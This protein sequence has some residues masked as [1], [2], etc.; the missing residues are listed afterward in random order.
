MRDEGSRMPAAIY[1]RVSSERQDVDLSISA[2]LKAIREYAEKGGYQVVRE[3]VDEAESG[4]SIDRP[5]FKAM[6]AS[7]RQKP[8]PFEAILVWKL[9][10]FARNREDS[11]IYKSLLR[12]Q[13]VQVISINEPVEDTPSGRLL[14]GIIEVIDEFYSANL[15]QDVVR[16]MRENA[17]RGFF[18]GS[19][20]PY[21]YRRIKAQD[22]DAQRT[23][24]EP[25]PATAPLVE[26]MFRECLSGKGLLEIT[27]GLNAD[28]LTTRTGRPWSKT[29]IH[30]VLRNEAY[31][32]VLLWGREKKRNLGGGNGLPP[33][34]VEGAWQPIID[35]ETLEKVQA[36][37]A[38]RA[39]KMTHPRVVHS[40]Y[41]L[42][43][44]I[45]C[46]ACGTAMIGH[47]VKS[48]KFF[49]YMCGNAR[50]RGREVCQ[51]PILPKDRIERFVI[52][53]IK[54]YIL[55]EENLEELVKLTNEELAQTC[56]E[57]RE[58]LQLLEAQLA[59]V[60]SRLG[61]L[62]DAL[63]TGEFKS[64]ELAPRIKALFQ[65]KEELQQARVETEEALRYRTIE[66]ANPEV[67]REYVQ[68]LK[69]LL[70]ESSI[71]EQKAFLKSFVER[72]EVDDSE[73][74]VVYTIPVLPDSSASE[75]VGV[76]PFIHNGP[77]YRTEARTFQAYI[78]HA[79]LAPCM[80]SLV[81]W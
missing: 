78:L 5:G 7:A 2:Q 46:K 21:G 51:T 72:I 18:P 71:L 57:E 80:A 23:K 9:S 41:I 74:K 26:R 68:D 4:R 25:D 20:V 77:P 17:S 64:G 69:A 79:S 39:P 32:G 70:E 49:Y 12:K 6:I 58:K 63:E 28:G 81:G 62:Y 22:G 16:G 40:E 38:A 45:R 42:S 13:G 8:A 43:G 30:K 3:Y 65:K 52:D 54:Q 53:R 15:S 29:T 1:A 61:K 59:D 24:L 11:I 55:T 33:V 31:T 47:S 48:G 14:E 60:D 56:D 37:L 10:R 50:R 44:M 19:P 34:R 73:A 67:V 76:L 35:R 36:R 75:A 66:L 27:R